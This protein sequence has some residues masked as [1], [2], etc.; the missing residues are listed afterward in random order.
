MEKRVLTLDI[1]NTAAK[2]SVF[3]GETLLECRSSDMLSEADIEYMALRYAPKGAV[4]CRV[5]KDL[6]GLEDY[7]ERCFGDRYLRLEPS[8]PLPL[9]VEYD[10]RNTLGADRVAAAAGAQTAMP[11]LVVDAGTAVTED[12]VAEGR[13]LGGN[14]SPGLSLRFRALNGYTSRLPLVGPDGEL[15]DFGHD[16][17]T[18]I[19]AG[20]LNGLLAEIHG[21]RDMAARRFGNVKI[22]LTGGDAGILSGLLADEGIKVEVDLAL[23]GRGLVRIFN[24]NDNYDDNE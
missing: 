10:S 13:F 20:V 21:V 8:T 24:Y 17:V 1:G 22:L 11:T 18:A 19:R 15:P 6:R 16:T 2:V 9:T 7:L 5:G 4:S 3:E 12:L 14:I 23:V